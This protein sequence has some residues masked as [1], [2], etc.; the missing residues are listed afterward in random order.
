MFNEN[1]WISQHNTN[2][3]KLVRMMVAKDNAILPK[4]L[5]ERKDDL[6]PLKLENIT[7]QC[8]FLKLWFIS[9]SM[10]QHQCWFASQLVGNKTLKITDAFKSREVQFA[11]QGQAVYQTLA[12]QPKFC[13]H[14]AWATLISYKTGTMNCSLWKEHFEK[15]QGNSFVKQI[16]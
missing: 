14:F 3:T 7:Y 11:V 15:I 13:F 6:Q 16:F 5:F 9:R 2:K 4:V 10:L 8:S 1:F 12:K